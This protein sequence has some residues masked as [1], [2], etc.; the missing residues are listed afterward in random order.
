MSIQTCIHGILMGI[1]YCTR[2]L[3][4]LP[5]STAPCQELFFV[6]FLCFIRYIVSRLQHLSANKLSLNKVSYNAAENFRLL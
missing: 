6:I 5:V 1:V 3:V 4:F 2:H